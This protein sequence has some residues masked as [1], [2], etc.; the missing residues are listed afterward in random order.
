MPL[1]FTYLLRGCLQR[2]FLIPKTPLHEVAN[3][4]LEGGKAILQ[5]QNSQ[6]NHGVEQTAQAAATSSASMQTE[7]PLAE[8]QSFQKT[9]G[10]TIYTVSV[11]F[12]QTSRENFEDKILRLLEREAISFA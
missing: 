5:Q 11:H 8:K 1:F 6:F 10:G 9:L 4:N 12:S 7:K 3:S 2:A